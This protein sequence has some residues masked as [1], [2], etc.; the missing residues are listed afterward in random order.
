MFCHQFPHSLCSWQNTT[1]HNITVIK[2]TIPR[3]ESVTSFRYHLK[4]SYFTYITES[5]KKPQ[6]LTSS[7]DVDVFLI[8]S[9]KCYICIQQ[10]GKP[11][12][13]FTLFCF[14]WLYVPVFIYVYHHI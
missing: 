13:P 9:F 4:P 7:Y 11:V 5:I 12:N 10:P 1:S 14:C 8:V 3:I 6:I 2:F